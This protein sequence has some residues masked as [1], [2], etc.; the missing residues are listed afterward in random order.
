MKH[1]E[2]CNKVAEC[3]TQIKMPNPGDTIK[4]KNLKNKKVRP[5]VIYA[6]MECTLVKTDDKM[7]I[8]RHVPNSCAF[9]YVCTYD[10]SRNV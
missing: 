3:G 7:K 1:I 8:A 5:D 10:S 2:L 6:D 4:F 9:I